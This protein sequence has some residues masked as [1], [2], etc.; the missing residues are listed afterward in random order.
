MDKARKIIVG[1][2]IILGL[3][4]LAYYYFKDD[5]KDLKN[6]DPSIGAIEHDLKAINKEIFAPEP[7]RFEINNNK[8]FL[9]VSGVLNQTNKQREKEGLKPLSL[10]NKLSESAQLKVDDMFN[11]QYFEHESPS[12]EGPGDLAKKVNYEYVMVGENL[13]LGN[14]S[15]D[16]AL[17]DGWMASP[18]HRENILRSGYTEIGIAVKEGTYE[19]KRTWLAVQEF[20]TPSSICPG[21]AQALHDEIESG[22]LEL[23]KQE[24][25]LENKKQQLDSFSQKSG[26]EY[27]VAVRDY[28][29]AVEL[30]NQL[31]QKIKF[32]VEQY[33]IEAESY[34]ACL[35]QF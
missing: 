34:N 19:G 3:G 9:T 23:T 5:I 17:V 28:N 25:L 16:K 7:L 1:L 33:N 8:V 24:V 26:Q 15:N 21:P 29:T 13:A 35:K 31:V 6:N 11:K 32:S 18:G 2:I 27:E 14:F 10:S 30:Y 4:A 20:G 12:G 22:K